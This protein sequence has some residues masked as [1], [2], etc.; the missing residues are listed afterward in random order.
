[1]VV[2]AEDYYPTT[3]PMATSHRAIMIIAVSGHEDQDDLSVQDDE[4]IPDDQVVV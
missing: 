2:E 3:V 4:E 1:M